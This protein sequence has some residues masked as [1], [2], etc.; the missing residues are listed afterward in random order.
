MEV[1]Q[2]DFDNGTVTRCYELGFMPDE[3]VLETI[4]LE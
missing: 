3:D 2:L 1:T 4:R